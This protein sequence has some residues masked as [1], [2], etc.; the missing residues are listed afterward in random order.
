M[1]VERICVMTRGWFTV[2]RMGT[3]LLPGTRVRFVRVVVPIRVGVEA[4]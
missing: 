2:L 3:V 4:M 1:N